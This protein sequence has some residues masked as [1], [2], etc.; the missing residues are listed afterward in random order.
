MLK[1]EFVTMNLL[2]LL[3]P[4]LFACPA[5][6]LQILLPL[7]E[8]P[9]ASASAW[10]NATAAIAA[11]PTVQWQVIINPN[12]GPNTI[13]YPTDPNYVTGIANLNGYPNVITLGYVDTA[14][15]TRAYSAVV[16]DVSVYAEWASY[17]QANISIGGIFFDDVVGSSG[18]AATE[19]VL[20]Y[21]HN[22]S[23]YAYAVVPS[24]ITP[25]VFNPGALGPQQ[26]FP[27]CDTMV[28]F[29][30]SASSY[31]DDITI[32]TLPSGNLGQSAIIIYDTMTTTDVKSLVHTMV[33]YGVGQ[34]YFDHG[35]C[36]YK[37][38]PTGCYNQSGAEELEA[39]AAAVA[40][41]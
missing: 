12:S 21:Y 41:G 1:Q 20:E 18:T 6:P 26:L 38:Q 8:Y 30:G 34:I 31:H 27:Y 14:Y 5:A 39:L 28:E 37:G 35:S 10:A 32:K 22:I 16:K 25:V 2:V 15:A 23:A 9:G 40:A 19:N 17:T 4:I 33:E 36:F 7:Y 29:E 11:Y 24:T 3:A 13:S